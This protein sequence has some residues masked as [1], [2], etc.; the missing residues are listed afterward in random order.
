MVDYIV[1]VCEALPRVTWRTSTCI[2]ISL[3][4]PTHPAA[5]VTPSRRP[6]LTVALYQPTPVYVEAH[7]PIYLFT[8]NLPQAVSIDMIASCDVVM[9]R[10]LSAF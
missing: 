2:V 4:L 5:V 6:L 1:V 8:A 3:S 10:L 9:R 7:L